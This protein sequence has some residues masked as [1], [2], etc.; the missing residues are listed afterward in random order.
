M[1]RQAATFPRPWTLAVGPRGR[2]L[3]LAARGD[4]DSAI[5]AFDEAERHHERLDAPYELG[6]TLLARASVHRRRTEK[7]LAKEALEQALALFEA[8]GAEPWAE[9]ARAELAAFA[10]GRRRRG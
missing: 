1:D 4:R 6:R 5:D 10:S 7:W 9:R 3:S 8:S 2:G